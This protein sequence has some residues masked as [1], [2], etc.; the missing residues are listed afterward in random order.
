MIASAQAA[1]TTRRSELYGVS[2]GPVH[3][4]P[5]GGREPGAP[6]RPVRVL[7]GL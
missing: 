4:P 5:G 7:A 2:T 6:W 1:Y 3:R